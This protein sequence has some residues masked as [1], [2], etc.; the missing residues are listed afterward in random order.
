[1]FDTQLEPSAPPVQKLVVPAAAAVSGN[2]SMSFR[3]SLTPGGG[4]RGLDKNNR[5]TVSSICNTGIN[6]ALCFTEM[7]KVK[8]NT[9]N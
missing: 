3:P 4:N 9:D 7:L 5:D 2:R 6:I 8:C 1:V